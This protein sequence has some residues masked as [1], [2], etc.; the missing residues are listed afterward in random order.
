MHCI[1]ETRNSMYG[2]HYRRQIWNQTIKRTLL[3]IFLQLWTFNVHLIYWSFFTIFNKLLS[4]FSISCL[5]LK[6]NWLFFLLV[7]WHVVIF[8]RK[9]K[10]YPK[11]RAF[12]SLIPN[13][14]TVVY[15]YI[16][17]TRRIRCFRIY[18]CRLSESKN[19]SVSVSL[20]VKKLNSTQCICCMF[21]S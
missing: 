3:R 18:I 2:V 7:S 9:R 20:D 12:C 17:A 16:R 13:F 1:F 14:P 19:M 21:N 8:I 4:R 10:K 5:Y 15:V 6:G 11:N